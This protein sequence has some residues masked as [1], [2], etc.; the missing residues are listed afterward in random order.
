ME[1]VYYYSEL[2]YG[3]V[4]Y[5]YTHVGTD[6]GSPVS[7]QYN[8]IKQIFLYF[9][10]TLSRHIHTDSI[11]HKLCIKALQTFNILVRCSSL[12]LGVTV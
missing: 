6:V 12:M 5:R 7:G 10:S 11:T 9:I 8:K 2:D 4:G 3:A 1:I